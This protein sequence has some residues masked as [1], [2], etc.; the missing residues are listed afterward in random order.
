[1]KNIKAKI[2]VFIS[3]ILVG[4]L[5]ATNYNFQGS[6]STLNLNAKEY[7][8]AVE[9]KNNLTK[10]VASL[11]QINSETKNKVNKYNNSDIDNVKIL[12]DMK[13]AD[14]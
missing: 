13:S 4:F 14:S 7:Q 9:T 8:N 3:T 1:M 11:R 12:E 6:S 10:Q 2:V 5:I